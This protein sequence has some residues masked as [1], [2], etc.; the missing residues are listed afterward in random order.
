MSANLPW[1]ER[2]KREN[3]VFLALIEGE[4][5]HDLNAVLKPIVDKFM[6]LWTGSWFWIKL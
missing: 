4:P 3:I 5:K 6:S 1:E 2:Y